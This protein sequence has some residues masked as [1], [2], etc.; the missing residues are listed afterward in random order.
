MSFSLGMGTNNQEM[1]VA[2]KS[3]QR[4]GCKTLTPA[5]DATRPVMIGNTQ[6]PSCAQTNTN[7][8][9]VDLMRSLKS[10]EATATP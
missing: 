8:R 2:T 1:A 7:A 6:P 5:L 4:T 9:A 10:L 3:A